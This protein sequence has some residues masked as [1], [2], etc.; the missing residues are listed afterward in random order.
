M[1]SLP[2]SHDAFVGWGY[3]YTARTTRS[4][5]STVLVYAPV[6]GKIKDLGQ[7]TQQFTTVALN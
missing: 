4:I 7:R 1:W 3:R 2:D 6:I 5:Y